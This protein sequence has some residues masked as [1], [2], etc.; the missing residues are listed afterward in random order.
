[1][2]LRSHQI[3]SWN[4]VAPGKCYSIF[5]QRRPTRFLAPSTGISR[6]LPKFTIGPCYLQ[7]S[8][9]LPS[10]TSFVPPSS[11]K[12]CAPSGY[13]LQVW[14][15]CFQ[16]SC[17][18]L[19]QVRHSSALPV[20]WTLPQAQIPNFSTIPFSAHLRFVSVLVYWRLLSSCW[21]PEEN[22]VG[23][24]LRRPGVG[25]VGPV[26]GCRCWFRQ[27]NGRACDLVAAEELFLL[28]SRCFMTS[29]L[30]LEL[31]SDKGRNHLQ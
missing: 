21:S 25:G 5:W 22:F 14:M 9:Y 7:G 15:P 10:V 24:R 3:S 28:W 29:H 23:K 12:T 27:S 16:H 19:G 6:R 17:A 11:L 13:P 2:S 30:C 1:M 4:Q 31:A 20:T 26:R 18:Y 8:W